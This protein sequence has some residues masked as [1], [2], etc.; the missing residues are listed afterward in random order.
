MNVC[1]DQLTCIGC[2]MCPGI[3]P[4]VFQMGGSGKAEAFAPATAENKDSVQEAIDSCPVSAISW[5][6]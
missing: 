3:A 6:A 1:V 4:E 5:Q 2:G